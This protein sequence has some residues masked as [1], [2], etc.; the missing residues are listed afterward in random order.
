MART[1]PS[2]LPISVADA[3]EAGGAGGPDAACCGSGLDAACCGSTLEFE[4]FLV[5]LREE[6]REVGYSEDSNLRLE[7]RSAD[8]KAARL[9]P[10]A[11]EL[12]RLKVDI[13]VAYQT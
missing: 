10:L 4:P 8:G 12:V 9:A 11:A 5:A 6:L 13:I 7:V 1:C 2:L 3:E